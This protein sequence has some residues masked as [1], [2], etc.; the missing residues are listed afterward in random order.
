MADWRQALRK[1]PKACSQRQGVAAL[2]SGQAV[3]LAHHFVP[4]LLQPLRHALQRLG[5]A[6]LQLPSPAAAAC[7][8]LDASPGQNAPTTNLEEALIRLGAIKPEP[9][10]V[11]NYYP[12]APQR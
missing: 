7:K 11:G 5:A 4:C 9:G 8:A 3:A 12:N 2:A 10:C 1:A 6:A